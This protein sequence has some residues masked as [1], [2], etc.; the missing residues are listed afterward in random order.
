[1]KKILITLLLSGTI[2]TGFT[3]SVAKV[4]NVKKFLELTGAGKL[5]VQLAGNMVSSFKKSFA[6]VP[7][8]F[9]DSIV[10]KLDP[11]TITNLVIPIYQ[12][13]YTDEDIQQLIVF[14]Q[15]PLGKK[16]IASTPQIM[17]ESMQVGQNWGRAIGE[18]IYNDL[19]AKGYKPIEQ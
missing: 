14:Y 5:G 3:Q 11:D 4:E 7:D 6:G 15:T 8:E 12:K 9:W 17:Q 10:K 18:K 16:V 2:I 13:Y 1:M 19:E